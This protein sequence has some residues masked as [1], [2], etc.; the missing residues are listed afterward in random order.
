LGGLLTLQSGHPVNI[1]SGQDNSLT[2]VGFDRPDLIGN[3]ALPDRS[4]TATISQ[5]FNVAAFQANAIGSYG[6][7]G[8]NAIIGPGL[9][10]WDVSLAKR[11]AITERHSL[12]LRGDGFNVLNKPNFG[13]PGATLAATG[14]FGRITS[15]FSGRILQVSL[16]YFF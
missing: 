11:F 3:P 12:Q 7:L 6:N 8:R 13:D 15:A 5:Y 10:N 16:K 2:G 4:R 9:F 1:L 14:A